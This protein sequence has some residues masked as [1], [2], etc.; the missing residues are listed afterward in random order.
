MLEC[1]ENHSFTKTRLHEHCL[2]YACFATKLNV[3]VGFLKVENFIG[4]KYY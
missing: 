1:N 3:L 2:Y 4:K